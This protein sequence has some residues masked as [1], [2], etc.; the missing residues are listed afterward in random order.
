MEHENILASLSGNLLRMAQNV[1]YSQH[2]N[3]YLHAKIFSTFAKETCRLI[4]G[5]TFS[6][7]CDFFRP[8]AIKHIEIIEAGKAVT[9]AQK[10]V[11]NTETNQ[12]L[13]SF[14]VDNTNQQLD[15]MVSKLGN[16]ERNILPDPLTSN[17]E[18]EVD[19]ECVL[20]LLESV[21][22]VTNEYV[23][24]RKDLSEMHRLQQDMATDL[25]YQMR[26]MTQTFGLLK[27]RI[28]A[29]NLQPHIQAQFAQNQKLLQRQ[30][31]AL[32]LPT[33]HLS[34]STLYHNHK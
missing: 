26:L 15:T 4:V 34:T 30:R 6:L 1:N 28:E 31:S 25:R 13:Q 3:R 22:D 12:T 19:T 24:L 8:V 17:P 27:Q 33:S 16:V 2:N 7:L 23:T 32:S 9:S 5:L 10:F 14:Q 29:K 21:S 18:D 20:E 11:I